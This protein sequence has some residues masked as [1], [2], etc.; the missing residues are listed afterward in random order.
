[1]FSAYILWFEMKKIM[2][3]VIYFDDFMKKIPYA[4]RYP[5]QY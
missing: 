1:M 3:L 5:S 2:F 4:P